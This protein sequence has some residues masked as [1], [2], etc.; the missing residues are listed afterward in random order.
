MKKVALEEGIR[1]L[2]E[3]GKLLAGYDVYKDQLKDVLDMNEIKVK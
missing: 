1:K 2:K 3:F